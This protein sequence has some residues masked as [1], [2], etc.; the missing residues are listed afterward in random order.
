MKTDKKEKAKKA[1]PNPNS[2][3][4]IAE[5]L[6]R[7]SSSGTYSAHFRVKGNVCKENLE[8]TELEVAKRKL[9]DLRAAKELLDPKAGKQT[10][11]MITE[12]H[13]QLQKKLSSSSITKKEG[14][15]KKI[16]EQWP[17]GA[18]VFAQ[19]V[20]PSDVEEWLQNCSD[21]HRKSTINEWQAFIKAVFARAV[22][23]G[24]LLK[25]P[26][27]ELKPEKREAVERLTPTT[28]Q[29]KAI[30][31]SIRKNKVNRRCK[32][33]ADFVEFMGLAG[34]GN[35]EAASLRVQDV[36]ITK[37]RIWIHR[38]KTGG[39]F[40]IPIFPRLLPLV[41]KLLKRKDNGPKA[42]LL[43]ISEAK[44]ALHGACER[45]GYSHF[46]QRSLRRMFITDAIERGVDVKVIA[47]WQGHKDGGKLILDTYS[48]VSR[49]HHDRMAE[50]MA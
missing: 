44:N 47:E 30:V 21:G 48:H 33:S 31:E 46:T 40:Y 4:R 1:A 18:D 29:F 22:K 15:V 23:D 34:I 37:K 25:S 5:G 12:R 35:G 6:Y 3:K 45:L 8:T 20:K 36:D 49:P 28:D 39:D 26:A 38:Q 2:L 24:V 43:D 7:N 9:R 17:G 27:V 41:T 19:D 14:I 13:M 11:R 42:K 32:L 16:Y 50:L 10:L